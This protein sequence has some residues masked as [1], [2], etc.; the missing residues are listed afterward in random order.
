MLEKTTQKYLKKKKRESFDNR[1]ED[2]NENTGT[3]I[4]T[5]Y[6]IEKKELM[7]EDS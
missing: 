1:T 5:G 2:T 7:S 3:F 6:V 4:D